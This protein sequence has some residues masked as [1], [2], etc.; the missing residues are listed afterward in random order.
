M[1]F[2]WRRQQCRPG[3]RDGISLRR[4]A[5]TL[6][7]LLYCRWTGLLELNSCLH[8]RW[9]RRPEIDNEVAKRQQVVTTSRPIYRTDCD[10]KF[11]FSLFAKTLHK[12]FYCHTHCVPVSIIFSSLSSS[13][14]SLSA[15]TCFTA[16]VDW[17]SPAQCIY[18]FVHHYSRHVWPWRSSNVVPI[19]TQSMS[20]NPSP[21]NHHKF[22]VD[23]SWGPAPSPRPT[24]EP[25][26]FSVFLL[27]LMFSLLERYRKLV[28]RIVSVLHYALGVS[29]LV[30][31]Y[32]HCVAASHRDQPSRRQTIYWRHSRCTHCSS[33]THSHTDVVAYYS[34]LSVSTPVS[35]AAAAVATGNR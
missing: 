32:T 29:R 2:C 27:S 17:W 35:A 31:V 19:T 23:N 13:S 4:Y 6:S 20:L 15:G 25:S 28:Y 3:R 8:D 22:G 5:V 26:L 30:P 10:S 24:L 14:S 16:T 9:D 21:S 33:L 12:L 7:S 34:S 11:I 18:G 1:A